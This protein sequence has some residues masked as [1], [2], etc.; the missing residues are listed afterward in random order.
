MRAHSH[1]KLDISAEAMK[2]AAKRLADRRLPDAQTARAAVLAGL[3]HG[4]ESGFRAG[5]DAGHVRFGEAVTWVVWPEG[6]GRRELCRRLVAPLVAEGHRFVRLARQTALENLIASGYGHAYCLNMANPGR[7]WKT[8]LKNLGDNDEPGIA[9]MGGSTGSGKSDTL[10]RLIWEIKESDLLNVLT[11]DSPWLRIAA[12]TEHS[13]HQSIAEFCVSGYPGHQGQEAEKFL[14]ALTPVT[15][16]LDGIDLLANDDIVGRLIMRAKKDPEFRLIIFPDSQQVEALAE[17]FEGDDLLHAHP[18]PSRREAFTGTLTTADGKTLVVS[19]PEAG[20]AGLPA[21]AEAAIERLTAS[22]AQGEGKSHVKR[23]EIVARACGH[24]SWHAAEGRMSDRALRSQGSAA[25]V[26]L[27]ENLN[28][29]L[30]DSVNLMARPDMTVTLQRVLEEYMT[31]AG[32]EMSMIA[33]EFRKRVMRLPRLSGEYSDL[34][35]CMSRHLF[36]DGPESALACLQAA[37]ASPDEI[38]LAEQFSERVLAQRENPLTPEL[39]NA[40]KDLVQKIKRDMD[41]MPPSPT[42]H[43]PHY[44]RWK[45]MQA[46]VWQNGGKFFYQGMRQMITA[47]SALSLMIAERTPAGREEIKNGQAEF[48]AWCMSGHFKKTGL[49][50]VVEKGA[51]FDNLRVAMIRR[52]ATFGVFGK[53]YIEVYGEIGE[54]LLRVL[55]GKVLA[56]SIPG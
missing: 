19:V 10:S 45:V 46:I 16:I 2:V 5:S 41:S 44:V 25:A 20:S 55:E 1:D 42:Y 31:A 47:K 21:A 50:H 33:L 18:V 43:P 51:F 17:A 11:V 52:P 53:R 7:G 54:H 49:T 15:V 48:D 23:L 26:S 13:D 9:V 38:G 8:T 28:A 27:L 6:E 24:R 14:A 40:A 30:E 34:D 32:P 39:L 22:L 12:D 37:N 56:S 4:T 3:R 29:H 36:L 35:N